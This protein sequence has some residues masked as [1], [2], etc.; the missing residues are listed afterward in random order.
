MDILGVKK[1]KWCRFPRPKDSRNVFKTRGK[2]TRAKLAD[3]KDWSEIGKND[4]KTRGKRQKD[5]CF[6][7][8]TAT[9][10]PLQPQTPLPFTCLWTREQLHISNS[11]DGNWEQ[12]WQDLLLHKQDRQSRA[13]SERNQLSQATLQFQVQRM[14]HPM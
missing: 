10:T 9:C 12:R 13:F 2:T 11:T 8:R 1:D 6:H 3:S 7:F 5:K 14:L 4:C